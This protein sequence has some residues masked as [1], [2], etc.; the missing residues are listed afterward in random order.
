MRRVGGVHAASKSKDV[1]PALG[2]DVLLAEAL[3]RPL[4]YPVRQRRSV[5]TFTAKLRPFIS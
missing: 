3:Q 2:L 4:R 5:A 1:E